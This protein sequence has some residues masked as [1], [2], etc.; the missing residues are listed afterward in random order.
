MVENIET[1]CLWKAAMEEENGSFQS[2]T[3]E[4]LP[5]YTCDGTKECGQKLNCNSY[6]PTELNS[7]EI[8]EQYS[9]TRNCLR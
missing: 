6:F 1:I 8:E 3:P 4:D 9:E 5:C 2:R 7:S